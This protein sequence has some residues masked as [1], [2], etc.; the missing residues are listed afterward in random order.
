MFISE[1]LR[2]R[3]L[4]EWRFLLFTMIVTVKGPICNVIRMASPPSGGCGEQRFHRHGNKNSGLTSPLFLPYPRKRLAAS[5]TVGASAL[6]HRHG[7]KNRG[8]VSPLFL[9]YPRKRLAASATGG[10]S[11]L[12]SRRCASPRGRTDPLPPLGGSGFSRFRVLFCPFAAFSVSDYCPL[13]GQA[14]GAGGGSAGD[15]RGCRTASIPPR[16]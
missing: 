16:R 11:A 9:P 15:G 14:H 10:A 4:A 3:H 6:F 8:P 13:R 1:C 2:N 12:S 7:D 5:A